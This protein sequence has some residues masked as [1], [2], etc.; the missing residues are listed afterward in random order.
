MF[1]QAKMYMFM[2]TFT[3]GDSVGDLLLNNLNEAE[4]YIGLCVNEQRSMLYV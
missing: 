4:R 2:L 1:K 3:K